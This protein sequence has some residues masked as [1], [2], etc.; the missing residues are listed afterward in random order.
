VRLRIVVRFVAVILIANVGGSQGGVSF[1]CAPRPRFDERHHQVPQ[2]AARL[3]I[4]EQHQ[5]RDGQDSVVALVLRGALWPI[6]IGIALG[7]PAALY[8]GRPSASLLYR[9]SADDPLAY[10][11]AAVVLGISA[12]AA[13]YIPARR[14]ASIDPMGALREE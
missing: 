7:V 2:V 1:Q 8:A 4:L 3:A 6:L 9:I 11:G 14:A 5:E 13:A 10:I 12:A